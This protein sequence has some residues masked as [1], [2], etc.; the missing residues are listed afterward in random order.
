MKFVLG[1]VTLI[2]GV[3]LFSFSSRGVEI[4][5]PIDDT[6]AL[7]TKTFTFPSNGVHT[8]GKIYLPPSIETDKSLPAIYLIDFTEQQFKLATV[9]FEK[10]V[11]GVS[12][13]QGFDALVVTLEEHLDIDAKP[14]AFQAYYDI[15]NHD[16]SHYFGEDCSV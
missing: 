13:I 9:E 7:N 15:F 11:D 8:K 4:I 1:L 12:K 2:L 10:V 5:V 3:V 6:T 14:E 16:C